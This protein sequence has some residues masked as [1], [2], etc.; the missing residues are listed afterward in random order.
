MQGGKEEL[1]TVIDKECHALLI[2][3]LAG[4]NK[5]PF[6]FKKRQSETVSLVTL[7]RLACTQLLK[8]D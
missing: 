5:L 4:L 7:Q 3:T 8:Q 1:R 6:Y 2:M